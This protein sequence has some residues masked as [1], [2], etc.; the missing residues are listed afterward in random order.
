ME[1]REH[2]QVSASI[3]QAVERIEAGNAPLW[4]QQLIAIFQACEDR[5]DDECRPEQVDKIG[6][7]GVPHGGTLHPAQQQRS[8]RRDADLIERGKEG[9]VDL[10]PRRKQHVSSQQRGDSSALERQ[11]QKEDQAHGRPPEQGAICKPIGNA[12]FS[13]QRRRVRRAKC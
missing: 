10:H 1:W 11:N 13:A 12:D 9:H 7:A 3:F 6:L 5:S 2:Q 4:V 8:N